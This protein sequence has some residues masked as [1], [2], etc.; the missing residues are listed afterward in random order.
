M[1]IWEWGYLIRPL[2]V[3]REFVTSIFS[4]LSLF[5]N[6][7]IGGIVLGRDGGAGSGCTLTECRSSCNLTFAFVS[8]MNQDQ[9]F[10]IIIDALQLMILCIPPSY[11]CM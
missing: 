10:C 7:G 9:P 4:F 11:L 1:F 3:Q 2:R 5:E 8:K 6:F